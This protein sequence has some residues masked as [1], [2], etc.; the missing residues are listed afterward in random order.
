MPMLS[1]GEISAG[2]K[3][4]SVESFD[5]WMRSSDLLQGVQGHLANPIQWLVV[6]LKC[7]AGQR[8]PDA[9]AGGL[10]A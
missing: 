9:A 3:T 10:A 4:E 2:L 7:V 8:F 1:Q 5:G 6:L